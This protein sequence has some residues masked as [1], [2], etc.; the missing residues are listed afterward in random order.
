MSLGERQGAPQADNQKSNDAAEEEVVPPVRVATPSSSETS[1][2][3]E[4]K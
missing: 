3:D 2:I 4:H 1:A